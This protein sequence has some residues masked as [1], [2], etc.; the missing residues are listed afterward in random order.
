MY[1][2]LLLRRASALTALTRPVSSA[3]RF[4]AAVSCEAEAP[5]K[6]AA[7]NSPFA[8]SVGCTAKLIDGTIVE[9]S[10]HT[11]YDENWA[12]IVMECA[13][14]SQV[15]LSVMSSVVALRDCG[16]GFEMRG[17]VIAE[18]TFGKLRLNPFVFAT[19][20]VRRL[21]VSSGKNDTGAHA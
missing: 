2:P 5:G 13:P 10:S 3:N 4:D 15:T 20:P 21:A 16:A 17:P 18:S 19:D 12:P 6:F 14:F 9:F 8:G 1:C 11:L 7:E